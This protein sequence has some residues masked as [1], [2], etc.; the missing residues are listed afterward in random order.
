LQV[1]MYSALVWVDFTK[2]KRLC[3]SITQCYAWFDWNLQI[4]VKVKI[5]AEKQ[6][7]I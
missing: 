6:F 1:M 2:P 4:I 7:E 3:Q 5:T